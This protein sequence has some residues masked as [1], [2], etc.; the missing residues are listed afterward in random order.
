MEEELNGIVAYLFLMM[1]KIIGF[2][3]LAYNKSLHILIIFGMTY[4]GNSIVKQD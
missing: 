3:H 1:V 4:E 2:G